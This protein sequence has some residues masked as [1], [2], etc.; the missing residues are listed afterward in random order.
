MCMCT[1]EWVKC[2]HS[3]VHRDTLFVGVICKSGIADCCAIV[4]FFGRGWSR[5]VKRARVF[6]WLWGE[7]VIGIQVV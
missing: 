5:E 6:L 1:F 2:V 4:C 7:F 3:F